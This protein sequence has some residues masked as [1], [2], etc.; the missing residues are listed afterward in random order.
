MNTKHILP[1]NF[2][3]DA[4][5]SY[6]LLWGLLL[7]LLFILP[8]VL[9]AEEFSVTASNTPTYKVNSS[10]SNRT[11]L[12]LKSGEFVTLKSAHQHSC[13]FK[14]PYKAKPQCNLAQTIASLT[15]RQ[16]TASTQQAGLW[17]IDADQPGVTCFPPQ[18]PLSLWRNNVS[19]PEQ[20]RLQ[21][22]QTGE[23]ISLIWP[24]NAVTLDW[25]V[26]ALPLSAGGSFL[27]M[28]Q[29]RTTLINLQPMPADLPATEL[30]TWM[31]Q[32][33]CQ[34]QLAVLTDTTAHP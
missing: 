22:Q 24:R 18:Q 28:S 23:N 33:G 26:E 32:Q 11:V 25:P 19:Q 4:P 8:T 6:R 5:S 31:A 13:T 29:Q 12:Q 1:A 21:A 7:S 20:L 30:H 17:M 16:R 14:G 2:R 34:R 27:L 9:T 3:F 10:L 15:P